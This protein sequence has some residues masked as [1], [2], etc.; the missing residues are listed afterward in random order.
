MTTKATKLTHHDDRGRLAESGKDATIF[1]SLITSVSVPV[2]VAA[3]ETPDKHRLVLFPP[4]PN[5]DAA[6]D[7][8][9]SVPRPTMARALTATGSSKRS[10]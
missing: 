6:V 9:Y 10:Y 2:I 7:D 1:D 8:K 5:S 3:C 4:Y